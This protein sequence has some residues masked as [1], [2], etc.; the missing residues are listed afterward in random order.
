MRIQTSSE[1]RKWLTGQGMHYRPMDC[2][3]PV[4]GDFSM[5][6][7]LE[8]RQQLADH[9]VDL[10][11]KDGNKLIEVLTAPSARA[12]DW[13]KLDTFRS[14]AG[15]P[16]SLLSAPG[17]LFKS[18]DKEHFRE[19]L[20]LLMSFENGWAF[21]I[22][23]APSRTTLLLNGR[24]GIWSQKKGPRNELGRHLGTPHAA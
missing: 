16:P 4:A 9:L 20:S 10:L 1:S 21:Y 8:S 2:G 18:A 5:P 17:H 14:Q 19:L 11:A 24:V 3:V 22:Y 6:A 23:A 12:E 7:D 15:N 13:E